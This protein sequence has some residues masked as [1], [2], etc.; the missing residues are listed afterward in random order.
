M[1]QLEFDFFAAHVVEEPEA[2]TN[3]HVDEVE[4]TLADI[5]DDDTGGA[6][7]AMAPDWSGEHVIR[8]VSFFTALRWVAQYH[9]LGTMPAHAI[10][11]GW[12][13]PDMKAIVVFGQPSN[14]HGVAKKYGL[15][16]FPGN[17]EIIRVAVH[18]D[19]PRNSAS[20][21]VAAA[22]D[23]FHADTGLAWVFSYADTGQGHHG[24]IYQ[25][26]GALYVGVSTGRPGFLMDG[27]PIHPRTVVSKFGT[28]G[29]GVYDLAK[30]AGHELVKVEGLNSDKHTYILPIGPP[31][32]RRRIR[33]ALEG[34]MLPYPK[35]DHASE[36]SRET[37]GASSPE[38]LVRSQD[39]ACGVGQSTT[40]PA[41]AGQDMNK[42]QQELELA[43]AALL[44]AW[45]STGRH[46]LW[47]ALKSVVRFR[48]RVE[49]SPAT[50]PDGDGA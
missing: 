22:C 42:L 12:F 26:L 19:A 3:G 47:L 24:G 41:T 29:A 48:D 18:P 44:R 27:E 33:R 11:Y 39:D 9:Y 23:T 4:F 1:S 43:E 38:G 6:L 36:V 14:A 5:P 28:Q 8:K 32:V 16:A 46:E 10:P 45:I 30:L 15:E 7:F 50:M 13:A 35:R 49:S 34:S 20:Q 37:R 25:A 40:Q 31:A 21:V 2:L 17:I